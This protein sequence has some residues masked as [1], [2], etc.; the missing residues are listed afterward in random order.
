M[1]SMSAMVP[2]AL[3]AHGAT[4]LCGESRDEDGACFHSS[5]LHSSF[6]GTCW[7]W[8]VWPNKAQGKVINFY[9]W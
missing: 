2:P 4:V 9:N 8:L 1:I 6:S 5:H 7:C 3:T